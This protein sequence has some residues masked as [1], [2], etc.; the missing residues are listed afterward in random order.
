M[1]LP[2]LQLLNDHRLRVL[3]ALVRHRV[4][5]LQEAAVGGAHEEHVV[6]RAVGGRH[7]G[8][9]GHGRECH[10]EPG[11]HED[12]RRE[13]GRHGVVHERVRLDEVQVGVVQF[14]RVVR[15]GAWKQ[16]EM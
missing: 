2:H 4:D 6:S 15:A 12:G 3:A 9:D 1:A 7:L 11:A 14:L 10:I 16:G 5:G 8:V 13:E